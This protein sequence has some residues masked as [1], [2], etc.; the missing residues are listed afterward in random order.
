RL[1]SATFAWWIG[2]V[3]VLAGLALAGFGSRRQW[4]PG[5][6]LCAALI[7]LGFVNV[8]NPEQMVVER[9]VA[10]ITDGADFDLSYAL[11]LSDDSVPALIDALAALEPDQR[12]EALTA[13]CPSAGDDQPTSWNL[14]AR[15]ATKA[16]SGVC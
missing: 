3:F 16:L 6:V 13:L 2:A 8:I 5:A 9:N 14:S 11:T 10:R 15:S 4:L 12:Q 1:Y 7:A